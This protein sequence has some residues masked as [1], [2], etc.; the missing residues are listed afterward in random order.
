MQNWEGRLSAIWRIESP[1]VIACLANKLG[2]LGWAEDL[3]QDAWLQ[4]LEHWPHKGV[5]HKP[6]AW[7][8]TVA[9]NKATDQLRRQQRWQE[10]LPALALQNDLLEKLSP[11]FEQAVE[12]E[13]NDDMLSLIF[14]ACH[15]ILS[16]EART[17]LTLKVVGGL[18]T[19]SIARAYLI[20]EKTLAQRLVRAKQK[21]R[22]AAVAFSPPGAQEWQE[23]LDAV[24]EVIYLIFNAGYAAG[25]GADWTR[26]RLCQE[27]M[28]QARILAALMPAESEVQGLLALLE[29]QASRLP[30]R[31][32]VNGEVILLMDQDRSAWDW[33]LV[34]RGLAALQRATKAAQSTENGQQALILGTYTLQA[35]IAACHARAPI[36]AETDWSRIA[37]LYGVLY[38]LTPSPV[39]ALNQV[40]AMG[41]AVGPEAGLTALEAIHDAEDL[42]HYPWYFSARGDFLERLERYTEAAHDF[43]RAATFVGNTQERD[44][45]LARAHQNR[46]KALLA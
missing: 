21:L 1:R 25:T 30:A 10:K 28:R 24:L 46:E 43:E 41:M 16:L 7:L 12:Q 38:Q 17:A 29:L 8:L 27:A 4:A 3:T 13:L 35:E 18:S 33:M 22:H 23:R 14:T 31:T 39:I 20:S 15:P 2:D 42:H 34:H 44:W 37:V 9:K 6:G 19:A 32:G 26:P 36:A 45:L 11:A 40:V 5:P